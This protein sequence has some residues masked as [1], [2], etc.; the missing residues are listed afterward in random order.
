[1]LTH[2]DTHQHLH[3]WPSVSEVVVR[4]AQVEGIRAVRVPR[5]AAPLKRLGINRLADRLS[6]Q[7][8][9]AGLA[10]P[11]WAAGLDE[12]G[13]MHGRRFTE[14]LRIVSAT[15]HASAELGCHPG[16]ADDAR[17]TYTWGYEWERELEW[18]TSS[19]ARA[20]VEQAGFPPHGVPLPALPS[21]RPVIVETLRRFAAEPLDVRLHT[22]LRVLSCPF[23]E[24]LAEVPT[25]PASSTTAAGTACSRRWPPR[26]PPP[27]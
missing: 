1:V 15:A 19:E 25:G 24:L 13:R 10:S 9:V 6:A 5:S 4:L 26:G 16:R 2:V 11:D 17:A 7:A 8:S 22:A 3:L 20:A 27:G 14:A 18:L 23:G 21:P 12:A